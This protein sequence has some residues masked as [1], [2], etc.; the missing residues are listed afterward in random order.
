MNTMEMKL[1]LIRQIDNFGR[2]SIPSDFREPSRLYP[3]VSATLF[4][5]EDGSLRIQPHKSICSLCGETLHPE[6]AVMTIR[7]RKI[8]EDCQEEIRQPKGDI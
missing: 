5:E 8:C 7:E 2:L 6:D 3:G 1:G 4:L